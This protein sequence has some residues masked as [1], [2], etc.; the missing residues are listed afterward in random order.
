VNLSTHHDLSGAEGSTQADAAI[1]WCWQY[2]TAVTNFVLSSGWRSAEV[3]YDDDVGPFGAIGLIGNV[4]EWVQDLVEEV[5][6]SVKKAMVCGTTAHLGRNSFKM[7]YYA[8]LFPENTN[9]DVG[10]RLA[11]SLSPEEH[12]AFREREAELKAL[13]VREIES[14]SIEPRPIHS[15]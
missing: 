2:R 15:R 1:D 4:K 11:R 9:P 7:G 13:S 8:T 3:A 10:F 5:A 14:L 12:A 6:S